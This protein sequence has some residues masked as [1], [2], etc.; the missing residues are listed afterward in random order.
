MKKGN[1]VMIEPQFLTLDA[2]ETRTAPNL[3]SVF[4]EKKFGQ[5]AIITE[6]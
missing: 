6:S 5:L 4:R 2:D 1:K 3:K